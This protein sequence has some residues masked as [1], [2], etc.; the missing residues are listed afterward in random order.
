MNQFYSIVLLA[1]VFTVLAISPATAQQGVPYEVEQQMVQGYK[2]FRFS[3]GGG[4]AF[5]LGKIQETGDSQLDDMS[6][7]LRHGYTVDAD[8]QYF[9]CEG[10]GLGLNAN[11]CSSSTSGNNVTI[12]NVGDVNSYKESQNILFVGPSFAG[13][14]ESEKFLLVSSIAIGPLFYMNPATLDGVAVK[15]KATTLGVNAGLAG[16]YKLNATTGIGL[17]LSYTVGNVKSVNVEGQKVEME[18]AFNLSNLMLTA[19]ISFRTW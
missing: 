15:T 4:Y 6:K 19:F 1:A 18:E 14:N 10:W 5:R 3:I 12:P 11:F 9:F 2:D 13:R 8:A 7:K 16:E 17:K